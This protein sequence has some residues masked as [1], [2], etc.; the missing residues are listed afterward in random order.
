MKRTFEDFLM[1]Q[2]CLEYTGSKD[3]ALE[4]FT[5]WLED[6]EIEDWLNY[7]QRYGIER[8][9]QAIDKVQ[10]ILRENRKEAK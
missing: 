7:G 2:H 4:A 5:Q 10:E 9:I 8:A 1:E 6:L 3:L